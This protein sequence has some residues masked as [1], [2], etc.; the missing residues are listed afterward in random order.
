M[1][2]YLFTLD[3][4]YGVEESYQLLIQAEDFKEALTIMHNHHIED[5]DTEETIKTYEEI[6]KD[7]STLPEWD[8]CLEIFPDGTFRQWKSTGYQDPSTWAEDFPLGLDT[9]GIFKPLIDKPK[10]I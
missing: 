4:S 5:S 9:T 8:Y 6:E 1:N 7:P 2:T 10:L 3:I